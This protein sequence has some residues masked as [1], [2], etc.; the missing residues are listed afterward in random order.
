MYLNSPFLES[1]LQKG[2]IWLQKRLLTIEDLLKFCEE[3]DFAHFSSAESGYQLCVQLPGTFSKKESSQDGKALVLD[4]LI[5]HTG[6]NLN[7]SFLTQDAAEAAMNELAYVPVL[8]DFCEIDGVRDFTYHAFYYDEEND[9]I[10]YQEKQIGCI[11]AD[12][13]YMKEDENV[14]GR[15]NVYAKVSIPRTYTDAADIIERKGGTD[16]SVELSINDMSYSKE[17]GLMLNDVTVLGLTCLGTDPNTGKKVNPGM[18][19]AHISLEDFSLQNNSVFNKAELV[20]EIT[21]AVMNKLDNH[22]AFAEENNH[23]KEDKPVEN[24][25]NEVIETEATEEEVEVT[26]EKVTEETPEV[27]EDFD[28]DGASE[29]SGGNDAS[30]GNTNGNTDT[31]GNTN[32]N[33]N[34]AN[35]A[36]EPEEGSNEAENLHGDLNNGQNGKGRNFVKEFELSHDDIRCGLYALLTPFEEADNEWYMI[37]EVYDDHFIYEGFFD[38]NNIYDQKYTKDGDEVAFEGER[39][40]MNKV[41]VTD[42]EYAQLNEM[43]SNYSSIAEKLAKYEE[44]PEKMNVLTSSAYQSI[45]DQ[46]DFEEFMKMEN[47]FDLSIDEV[48]DKA[49]A[50]LLQ[51][52]KSGKLNFAKIETEEKHGESRKDFFAFARIEPDTSFL[53]KLLKK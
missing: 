35:D 11:T 28:D 7:K 38:H 19:N 33:T 47:H 46:K 52:A 31:N 30:G 12:P 25:E 20:E 39:V 24:F 15:M 14:K 40:H 50:M 29:E 43:R 48:K 17:N 36:T 13:A 34:G 53:D 9:E 27:V 3:H 4:A 8:A 23:G 51:Y 45:A 1:N 49:D 10:V 6:K 37:S 32:G 16:V 42:S 26:E 2:G 18:E 41:V 5:F 21:Q 22:T 44:E